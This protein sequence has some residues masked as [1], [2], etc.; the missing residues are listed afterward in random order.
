MTVGSRRSIGSRN[1]FESRKSTGYSKTYDIPKRNSVRRIT[2]TTASVFSAIFFC[3]NTVIAF[4]LVKCLVAGTVEQ[5]I[6]EHDDYHDNREVY[7]GNGG[8]V[9]IP[10]L[11]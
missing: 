3:F 2:V 5:Y 9:F 8:T 4:S 7:N 11:V 10:S 6:H 1:A